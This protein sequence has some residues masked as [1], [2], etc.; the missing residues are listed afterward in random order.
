LLLVN[1]GT[2]KTGYV[3]LSAI[4]VVT[5]RTAVNESDETYA[6]VIGF[7]TANPSLEL[8][9]LLLASAVVELKLEAAPP[10]PTKES[11]S[12]DRFANRFFSSISHLA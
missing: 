6:D 8:I 11:P 7:P 2:L 12:M 9:L 10:S 1:G 5:G 4:T 3:L